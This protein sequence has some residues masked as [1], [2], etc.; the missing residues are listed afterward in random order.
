MGAG[1]G[2]VQEGR[3]SSR[4]KWIRR[5]SSVSPSDIAHSWCRRDLSTQAFGVIRHTERAD[6]AFSF[7]RGGRWTQSSDF[8]QWSLD[9]PLSDVGIE[10]ATAIGAETAQLAR[11]SD[12]EIHVII[13]SPYFRCVQTAVEICREL[14]G[15]VKLIVDNSIGEI[16]GPSIMGSDRPAAPVRPFK[17]AIDYCSSHGVKLYGS[18]IG[19][20][21]A[22]PEDLKAAR[23]RYANCFLKY[24]H[25]SSKT[26]RNFILVTH[27]DGVGA[28]LHMMPSHA[29]EAVSS[30]EYGARFFGHRI[31]PGVARG[32]AT[33]M[34]SQQ[35]EGELFA[36]LLPTLQAAPAGPREPMRDAWMSEAF[37]ETCAADMQQVELPLASD[38]WQVQTRQVELRP[39]VEHSMSRLEKRLQAMLKNSQWS[40]TQIER[41]LG[42][43]GDEPLGVELGAGDGANRMSHHFSYSTYVFGQSER[44]ED[45]GESFASDLSMTQTN[46]HR[47]T[48]TN[49]LEVSGAGPSLLTFRKISLR[50]CGNEKSPTLRLPQTKTHSLTTPRRRRSFGD[51]WADIPRSFKSLLMDTKG[52]NEKLEEDPAEEHS[53]FPA[54]DASQQ[55]SSS[56]LL[57]C[58]TGLTTA[59]TASSLGKETPQASPCSPTTQRRRRS[60]GEAWA[61]FPRICVSLIRD[62]K[63][64]DATRT[65][66]RED[67]PRD[68][69]TF[70]APAEPL[71]LSTCGFT[72]GD[73]GGETQHSSAG[74]A[75]QA[76]PPRALELGTSSLMQRRM[77]RMLN[78]NGA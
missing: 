16:F 26:K 76:T 67:S 17:D 12:T 27:A 3:S 40:R 43:L 73:K 22:W 25:R 9:P 69:T 55:T 61:D 38:G 51:A 64:V 28:A 37:G 41:L 14:G 78:R 32:G 30:A 4:L 2:V 24:L 34:G 56:R 35:A 63:E 74:N 52:N 54:A 36:G 46:S 23:R 19:T 1:H 50:S 13:S 6:D 42:G 77:Q 65:S 53:S 33:P 39:R 18:A 66:K 31:V 68:R 5:R 7:W 20:M 75:L 11:D 71:Q 15:R 8:H 21:P 57:A 47:S 45:L 62:T 48:N 59:S 44:D 10:Q 29:G 60:L 58:N 70:V 49:T 72:A